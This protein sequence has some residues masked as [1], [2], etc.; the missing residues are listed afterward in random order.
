MEN[1]ILLSDMQNENINLSQYLFRTIKTQKLTTPSTYQFPTAKYLFDYEECITKPF[2]ETNSKCE[3]LKEKAF[4][5]I[6]IHLKNLNNIVID[7]AG[8]EIIAKDKAIYVFIENCT[9]ITIKNLTFDYAR[10]TMLEF[11]VICING[12][13]IDVRFH[14]DSWYKITDGKLSLY[15]LNSPNVV[16]KPICHTYSCYQK[17]NYT[18][19]IKSPLM[20]DNYNIFDD[21]I[22]AK[23]LS[24]D[25]V[26]LSYLKAPKMVVGNIYEIVTANMDRSGFVINNSKG[27][28]FSNISVHYMHGHGL[29]CNLCADLTFNDCKFI[30]R[31]NR[32]TVAY[33]T[34]IHCVG[35][36]GTIN[37][38]NCN[39]NG[40]N[41]SVLKA[42]GIYQKLTS[43]VGK[44]QI[45]VKYVHP[46]CYNFDYYDIGDTIQFINK[47]SLCPLEENQITDI[48]EI[49]VNETLLTL[50]YEI[51]HKV[52][53]GAK[54]NVVDNL[55]KN[56]ANINFYDNKISNICGSG[57]EISTL[58]KTTIK[59]NEF[60]K[61]QGSAIYI[62]N[63]AVK[64]MESSHTKN[65]IITKNNFVECQ[66]PVILINPKT[67]R[68]KAF[69]NYNFVVDNNNFT[70]KNKVAMLAR[71]TK[72]IVFS[73]NYIS[74]Q[75]C[76][77][78][79]TKNCS[80][81]VYDNSKY[82]MEK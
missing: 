20:L 22:D 56:T 61:T 79:L 72:G 5:N 45:S 55:S 11:E 78:V 46:S 16:D 75:H 10:P 43:I 12:N 53:C 42:H 33:S 24:S 32:H 23:Q 74:K 39:F 59:N 9:D 21:V 49:G 67:R 25:I 80:T 65:L 68:N 57:I 18:T 40:S 82:S 54:H 52:K 7:G 60:F 70:L 13:T 19:Q 3:C 31:N 37:V 48:Q 81:V 71:S 41:Q 4:K 66:E 28:I 6:A 34:F 69:V 64:A 63:D 8:S 27:I 62:P 15:C 44:N 17:E 35:C 30:P 38:N 76:K 2:Y 50:K 51:S 29:L 73:N 77:N 58:G 36:N 14:K 1:I 26:R 47:N